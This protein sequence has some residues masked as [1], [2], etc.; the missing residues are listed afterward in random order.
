MGAVHSMTMN[1][2]KNI[3]YAE[4]LR[5]I[6]QAERVLLC[7]HLAPDGDALGSMLALGSLVKRMGKQVTM[8]C[9]DPVPGYLVFLP[10]QQAIK[11]PAQAAQEHFDLAISVDASDAE[12]LGDSHALFAKCP[13]TIQMDHHQTNTRFA[14]HN[15]VLAQLPASGSVVFPLFEAAGLPITREEAIYLYTAIST[16]TGNFCFGHISDVTFEQVAATMRAGLPLVET[17]R[18]LHLMREKEQVLMLG[19]AFNSLKFF[20][21]G[22]LSGMEI[23]Q[24]DYLDCCATDEHTDKIVNHGLYIP[25]CAASRLTV[26]RISLSV[27]GA[28]GT[29]RL[30]DVPSTSL[31]PRPYRLFVRPW[32]ASCPLERGN[33]SHQAAGHII[34]AGGFFC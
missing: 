4:I 15:L 3:E 30:R 25:V 14:Q 33:Q 8:I 16:D 34:S 27:W 22:R 6:G 12:R 9:H 11:L 13:V 2:Q 28:A 5:L 10:G 17:A 26:Y 24:Q 7:T 1:N 29:T 18:R 31:W 21:D 32:K 23:T 20:M 19:R